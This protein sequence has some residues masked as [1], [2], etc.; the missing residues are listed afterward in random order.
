MPVVQWRLGPG[1]PAARLHPRTPAGENKW[2]LTTAAT[3]GMIHS[4]SQM[5]TPPPEEHAPHLPF[6]EP[7]IH[8][9][10][11]PPALKRPIRVA[12]R[13]RNVGSANLH[14]A[15]QELVEW[16]RILAGVGDAKHQTQHAA[17]ASPSGVK[18]AP[19]RFRTGDTK[20]ISTQSTNNPNSNQNNMSNTNGNQAAATTTQVPAPATTP[21]PPS[22]EPPG[23]S[24]GGGTRGS[25]VLP[26][27]VHGLKTY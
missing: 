27:H 21:D 12:K 8:I 9:A 13:P 1:P 6:F 22:A 19:A 23:S 16:E 24:A 7:R 18:D 3:R 2:S 11:K 26:P 14:G 15:E 25:R 20:E 4:A 5:S 17:P 10:S